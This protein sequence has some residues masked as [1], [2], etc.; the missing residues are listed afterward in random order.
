MLYSQTCFNLRNCRAAFKEFCRCLL[1]LKGIDSRHYKKAF[2]GSA[3]VPSLILSNENCTTRKYSR[4]QSLVH[5]LPKTGLRVSVLGVRCGLILRY[6]RIINWREMLTGGWAA[7]T[8]LLSHVE[9]L[10]L[11]TERRPKHLQIPFEFKRWKLSL[12][13]INLLVF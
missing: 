4:G 13:S 1:A 9:S 12:K 5:I 2:S 8:K 11:G 7:N 3:S 6:L 10:K